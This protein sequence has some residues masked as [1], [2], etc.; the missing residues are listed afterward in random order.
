M[1]EGEAPAYYNAMEAA[2]VADLASGV[3]QQAGSRVA[4]NDLGVI[5]T[6]RK[7]ARVVCR[8]RPL[9]MQ[10]VPQFCTAVRCMRAM[11]TAKQVQPGVP[12]VP[13]CGMCCSGMQRLSGVGLLRPLFRASFQGSGCSCAQV[14]K[15]RLLLRERGLG[16]VRVGTVDDYQGQEER[17][18]L[19]STAR[20]APFSY[21]S[22]ALT[23]GRLH[24]A[25]GC[26]IGSVRGCCAN[27]YI[28]VWF[29]VWC[30]V[31]HAFLDSLKLL[32][33]LTSS[34]SHSIFDR[35]PPAAHILLLPCTGAVAAGVS[36]KGASA[37]Q[38]RRRGGRTPR[39]LAEPQAL[40]RGHH[41]RQG[42]AGALL[43]CAGGA[44]HMPGAC[45]G[46]A[47]LRC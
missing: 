46:V 47:A 13:G 6:Y 43:R 9:L 1:R 41:A 8:N 18:I 35:R 25:T 16:A 28:K 14:Q 36:A 29:L 22:A 24:C 38:Q 11:D 19:I 4:A 42:A 30:I 45:R 5:A 26:Q 27:R 2:A 20:P 33:S 17:I 3:L 40:Q 34:H 37:R 23:T 12:Q 10:V 39:L 44:R 21:P 7:Q 15:I 32:K 31:W